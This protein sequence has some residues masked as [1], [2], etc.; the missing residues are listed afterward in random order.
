MTEHLRDKAVAALEEIVD[1]MRKNGGRKDFSDPKDEC[2]NALYALRNHPEVGTEVLGEHLSYLWN[3]VI[4]DYGDLYFDNPLYGPALG[5][6]I[7]TDSFSPKEVEWG[8]SYLEAAR[9]D[10]PLPAI[11]DGDDLLV[12]ILISLSYALFAFA[13]A[14]DQRDQEKVWGPMVDEAVFGADG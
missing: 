1:S 6:L 3:E 10:E 8:V 2:R 13:F 5:H 14:Q 11:K 4:E 7:T 9:N 12:A